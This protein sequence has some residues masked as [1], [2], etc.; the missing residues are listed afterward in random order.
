MFIDCKR[1]PRTGNPLVDAAHGRLAQLV[2]EAYDSWLSEHNH[3]WVRHIASLRSMIAEHFREEEALVAHVDPQ[4]AVQLKEIHLGYLD[5]LKQLDSS[6]D[7]ASPVDFFT[8][9]EK[10]LFEHELEEDRLLWET[11]KAPPRANVSALPLIAW[12]DDLLVGESNIDL[13]HQALAAQLNHLSEQLAQKPGVDEIAASL[14]DI[15][16]HIEGHFAYE[17]R[18][19]AGQK[20]RGQESHAAL[21][22]HLLE[23]LQNVIR[24]V[25]QR[26]YEELEDLLENY[27]KYW[28]LDHILHVDKAIGRE[29]A[30]RQAKG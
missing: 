28:L 26:R 10:L 19:M 18:L 7:A 23:D 24:D 3:A 4:K 9:F 6:A 30:A 5:K 20:L 11:K 8:F 13:Q 2:N 16:R 25:G 12:S 15:L 22:R 21:H 14:N 29:L 27:L 17:E 1:I